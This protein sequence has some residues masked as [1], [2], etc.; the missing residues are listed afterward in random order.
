MKKTL[1]R[2]S[3]I[4]AIVMLVM[5]CPLSAFA[6]TISDDYYTGNDE[7]AAAITI[8]G[9]LNAEEEW[10]DVTPD[11]SIDITSINKSLYAGRNA[12]G[13]EEVED[14]TFYDAEGTKLMDMDDIIVEFYVKQDADNVYLAVTIDMPKGTYV[15]D[16]VS[17]NNWQYLMS[18]LMVGF[19]PTDAGQLISMTSEG[20]WITQD[21]AKTYKGVN[22]K[23]TWKSFPFVMEGLVKDG[24]LDTE[25]QGD[26]TGIITHV[27]EAGAPL[28]SF[29]TG[30]NSTN[31]KYEIKM[32]KAAIVEQYVEYYGAD[33]A[34]ID[35]GSM[36]ISLTASDY[37]WANSKSNY[38]LKF[39]TAAV[40]D[41]A[42]VPD[43]IVFGEKPAEET[44]APA[45]E[46]P[47]TEAPVVTPAAGLDSVMA[48]INT[49]TAFTAST[50]VTQTDR[51][52]TYF[53]TIDGNGWNNG[54]SVKATATQNVA[55]APDLNIYTKQTA[56]KLYLVVEEISKE[57][58]S[59]A[60]D[61]FFDLTTANPANDKIKMNS[62]GEILGASLCSAYR[63][64]G[65]NPQLPRVAA[66]AFAG[67][68]TNS[69]VSYYAYDE[70]TGYG[71]AIEAATDATRY[72]RVLEVEFDKALLMEKE[73]AET[74]E[75]LYVWVEGVVTASDSSTTNIVYARPSDTA[76]PEGCVGQGHYHKVAANCMYV[77]PMVIAV[78]DVVVEEVTTEE[79]TTEA[80]TTEEE[81]TAPETD[82]PETTPPAELDSVMADINTYYAFGATQY[83][84]Q[85][86]R[87]GNYWPTLNGNGWSN[88]QPVKATAEQNTENA[89]TFNIYT[90]QTGKK[91]YLVI[92][93]ISAEG[94]SYAYDIFFGFTSISTNVEKIKMNSNGDI[95][96]SSRCNTYRNGNPVLPTTPASAFAG[97]VLNSNVTYYSYD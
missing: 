15:V 7:A 95:L 51:V 82:A 75:N 46:A 78:G 8:D 67:V 87:I 14:I 71:D 41:G 50:Y 81:T 27:N 85:T 37:K 30:G 94:A 18:Y 79:V 13:F 1:S 11:G 33:A 54:Y 97:V 96:G 55:N 39:T 23:A 24:T 66:S 4:L 16:G 29:A 3:L 21:A 28:D 65:G 32:N 48:N 22:Y 73:S 35:F 45:T 77:A 40:V 56:D 64:S 52:G 80:P 20:H 90:K 57:G 17:Y 47:S 83:A 61:I 91:F 74:L 72:A 10:V 89:S 5:A 43:K 12:T 60:Y 26:A 92:E 86:D 69:N 93:E 84:T 42:L 31:R 88:G 49:Y 62:K 53:P 76:W 19:N 68:V 6:T 44:E 36:Y 25:K 63:P 9:T 2:I 38:A 59:Y 34:D 58:A 70:A